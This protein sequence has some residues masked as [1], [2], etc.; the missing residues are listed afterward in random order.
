MS[1]TPGW[2]AEDKDLRM[3]RIVVPQSRVGEM[4]GVYKY[5]Y[6]LDNASEYKMFPR[7]KEG[8]A[9]LCECLKQFTP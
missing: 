9:E 1:L 4:I 3:Y 6:I 8:W 7:T 2:I 5:E